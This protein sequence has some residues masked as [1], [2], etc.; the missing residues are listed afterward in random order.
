MGNPDA[1]RAVSPLISN[2]LLVAIVVV[3]GATMSVLALG[4]TDERNRPGPVIGESSGE[5]VGDE[6]GSDDQIVRITHVAGDPVEVSEMEI[7][8]R[9]CGK[10]TRIVNLPAPTNR[11]RSTPTYFPFDEGNFQGNQNLLSQGTVGQSWDAGVLHEDTNDTFTSGLSFEFRIT[12]GACSLDAGDEV[13]VQVV[14]RPTN[15]V[16]IRKELTA[17]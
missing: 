17:S 13:A 7:V 12:N 15:T 11:T 14:H 1:S 3:L 5:L 2:V 8:V 4:V 10:T 9:A 16:M 6:A